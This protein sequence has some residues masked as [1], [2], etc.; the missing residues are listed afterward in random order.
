MPLYDALEK[1]KHVGKL[2]RVRAVPATF[3]FKF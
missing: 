3:G 1:V 2:F